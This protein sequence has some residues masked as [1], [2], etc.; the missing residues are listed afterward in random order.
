MNKKRA[1]AKNLKVLPPP[2]SSPQPPPPT[3][4]TKP[5]PNFIP[6]YGLGLEDWKRDEQLIGYA[7]KLFATTEFQ[8]LID[9][10]RNTPPA[11]TNM[12]DGGCTRYLG[13]REG[14]EHTIKTL[15][16]LP[17]WPVVPPEAIES[18]YGVNQNE[19]ENQ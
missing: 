1:A 11:E 15:L 13:R 10:L 18:T 17:L 9:V 14:H 12:P 5:R 8:I 19:Q 2:P 4:P 3:P 6:R 7:K 16:S